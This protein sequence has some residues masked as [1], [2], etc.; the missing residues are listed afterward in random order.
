M[1]KSK[2]SKIV[3][4]NWKM[5]IMP[6]QAHQLVQLY[7]LQIGESDPE[8]IVCPPFS[9]IPLLT[10]YP[11]SGIQIGAQNC[12][13]EASGAFTGE[14]SASMLKDLKCSAVILGHSECRMRNPNE[15]GQLPG[16][17]RQAMEQGLKVIYCCGEP[18]EI[19]EQHDEFAYVRN[20]LEQ[21]LSGMIPEHIKHL[22]IA[23]EP[24]WAIGTGRIATITQVEAMHN[25][26]R[27]TLVVRMNL[28]DD[29][30]SVL[31]GG[32]VNPGNVAELASSPFV[33]GVLVGGSSLKPEEF[34]K[35][36]EAFKKA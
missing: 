8:C 18:L 14:I 33:D 32:S 24:I 34:R 21:D 3:A 12:S 5:N 30:I 26:I 36:Y 13:A 25:F 35:I 23:Y 9:H 29:L 15:S 17:I 16:K 11:I 1:M 20:Q 19:R 27:E 6:S 10:L 22:V 2:R 7:Q 4:A 28:F 31:Y